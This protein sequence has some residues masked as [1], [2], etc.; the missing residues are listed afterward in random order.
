MKTVKI[1]LTLLIV[2]GNLLYHQ[3]PCYA[4]SPWEQKADMQNKRQ[5]HSSGV[6]D[7][8]VYVVGGVQHNTGGPHFNAIKSL[9]FYDPI[10]DTWSEKASMDAGRAQFPTCV[11][12]GKIWA[13][14]GGQSVYWSPLKSIE[15]YDP[16]SDTWAQ[17]T[18]MPRARMGHTASLVDGKIY[19]IGGADSD[20]LIPISEIV[21]YD[22]K[23]N[24]W[25]ST[26]TD[27]PTARMNLQAVVLNGKIYAIGG[28]RGV[29]NNEDGVKTVEVYDPATDE[30]ETKANMIWPRKYFS[31]CLLD[32]N[33][34]VFG[35]GYGFC[36][37]TLSAFD[38]YDPET[39]TWT[40]R[41]DI[42]NVWVMTAAA[43]LN[44]KAYVSGG[45]IQIC[46]P[47]VLK[48]LRAYNPEH[49]LTN[50]LKEDFVRLP[51]EFR[52]SQNYPNPFNP[53]TTIQF[54]VPTTCF[55][56][57]TV[58]TL[59]GEEIA[60]LVNEEKAPGIYTVDWE[61]KTLPSGMYLYHLEAGDY[62]ETR[63]L[64]LQK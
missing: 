4:Q 17:V 48:T 38:A 59:L 9:E 8:K 1:L 15:A 13:I 61:N 40:P 49:D 23:T 32:N 33:I 10:L 35:G 64:V 28:H 36:E 7:G 46:P 43:S 19:I 47:A 2:A 54:Q 50:S 30:W 39:D 24:T 60:V 41:A 27:L 44:G 37:G 26:K 51:I 55:V 31:A 25:D 45:T 11:F 5:G 42:P 20:K 21:V 29:A 34:Y 56:S 16:A 12:E 62:V 6:L 57:L 63:R 22:P 3:S 18:D 52:M 53:G 14:G 58:Y